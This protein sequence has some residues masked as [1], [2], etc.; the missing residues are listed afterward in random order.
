MAKSI[1]VNFSCCVLYQYFHVFS[2]SR[3]TSFISSSTFPI[4]C[5]SRIFLPVIDFSPLFPLSNSLFSTMSP[6]AFLSISFPDWCIF[7]NIEPMEISDEEGYDETSHLV[8][9]QKGSQ[10]ALIQGLEMADYTN[11]EVHIKLSQILDPWYTLCYFSDKPCEGLE[12]SMHQQ[13]FHCIHRMMIV[14][15]GA[16]G[17]P[18]GATLTSTFEEDGLEVVKSGWFHDILDRH[19]RH[20]VSRCS[21]RKVTF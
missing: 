7:R 1:L 19:L 13:R 11:E 4:P 12:K 9:L 20:R 2:H 17:N 8:L 5:F 15:F 10:A 3:S 18:L 21:S 14:L 16:V 6:S